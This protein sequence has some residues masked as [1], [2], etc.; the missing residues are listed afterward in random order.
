MAP[1]D[2][3]SVAEGAGQE[4]RYEPLP[5][6]NRGLL[7]RL[8]DFPR[9][10]EMVTH[11]LRL[12][13]GVGLRFWLRAFHRFSV[14][15][16][17]NLPSGKSFILVANHASH[18]DALCL[19]SALP[20]G[21]VHRVFPAAAADYFFSSLPRTAFSAVFINALPFERKVKGAQSLALC[22]A[23]LDT[24]GNVL[25]LF[26]EGTR[27]TTGDLARFRSGI[28][29]LVVGR[30]IP[31]IPCHLEGAYRAWPK[32]RLLPRP[33]RIRLSI[34][35]QRTYEDLNQDRESVA[36]ICKDLE[37]SV[38]TLGDDFR[39]TTDRIAIE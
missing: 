29:R 32:G 7:Q 28:A 33:S 18:L 17:D 2:R 30:D 37:G 27:S 5:D 21:S 12:L 9:E 24:P 4:W 20:L 16:R 15:G 22:S 14:S 3:E 11:A 25:I 34:G 8:Q 23:L 36:E 10:P 13:G 6:L 1:D 38:T 26:P 39:K 35:Q 31:V 19:I